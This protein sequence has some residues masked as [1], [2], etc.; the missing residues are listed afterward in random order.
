MLSETGDVVRACNALVPTTES[1]ARL[2]L[3]ETGLMESEWLWHNSCC[4]WVGVTSRQSR[5]LTARPC[6]RPHR[7]QG[8]AVG[9]AGGPCTGSRG[10]GGRKATERSWRLFYCIARSSSRPSPTTNSNPGAARATLRPERW[11]S[12]ALQR[13]QRLRS[14]RQ[15]WAEDRAHDAAKTRVCST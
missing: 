5:R 3:P 1:S 8:T 4:R 9:T 12:C 7:I 6:G 2:R 14:R 11:L 15:A 13:S 10:R